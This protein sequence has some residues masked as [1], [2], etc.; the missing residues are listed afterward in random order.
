MSKT[1]KCIGG[2]AT[3]I[4]FTVETGRKDYLHNATSAMYHVDSVAGPDGQVEFL[5]HEDLHHED[6]AVLA[7]A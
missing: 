1:L 2:P 6:A 3:D 4:S 7:L 5:R